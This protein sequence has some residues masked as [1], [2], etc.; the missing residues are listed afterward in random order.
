MKKP[1]SFWVRARDSRTAFLCLGHPD[2]PDYAVLH[3]L[4][5]RW[6]KQHGLCSGQTI[7]VQLQWRAARTGRP[8]L[9]IQRH[10]HGKITLERV[11]RVDPYSGE[12]VLDLPGSYAKHFDLHRVGE[13]VAVDVVPL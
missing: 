10:S 6:I 8:H 9:E 12:K 11:Y 5:W 1:T 7:R 13:V 4:G 3:R 2:K